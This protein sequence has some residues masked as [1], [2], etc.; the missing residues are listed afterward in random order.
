MAGNPRAQRPA[1]VD[2]AAAVAVNET[3]G[4]VC[5]GTMGTLTAQF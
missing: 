5:L 2:R 4:D 3:T 1:L